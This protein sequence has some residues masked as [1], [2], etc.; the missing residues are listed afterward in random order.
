MFVI[1]FKLSNMII[2][3]HKEDIFQKYDEEFD[4]NGERYPNIS[5]SGDQVD[6]DIYKMMRECMLEY[7]SLPIN[8]REY[9]K[10]GLSYHSVN[11]YKRILHPPIE[12]KCKIKCDKNFEDLILTKNTK[13]KTTKNV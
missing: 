1:D 13:S 10:Y 11:N 6:E 12:K 5:F 2:K 4:V 7:F 3:K 8:Y 9:S